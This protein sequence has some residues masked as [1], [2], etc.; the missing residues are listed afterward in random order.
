MNSFR[1]CIALLSVLFLAGAGQA[2]TLKS[3]YGIQIQAGDTLWFADGT[4]AIWTPEGIIGIFTM[5]GETRLANVER[6]EMR[7]DSARVILLDTTVTVNASM[8][9]AVA[10]DL[11]N[12]EDLGKCAAWGESQCVR[13]VSAYADFRAAET[14]NSLWRDEGIRLPTRGAAVATDGGD[15]VRVYDLDN[16]TQVLALE[17]GA[18]NCLQD[19]SPVVTDLDFQDAVLVISGIGGADLTFVDFWLDRAYK[20]DTGG[21]QQYNGALSACNDGSGWR[22]VASG[23]AINDNN[24][25]GISLNRSPFSGQAGTDETGRQRVLWTIAADVKS[26]ANRFNDTG[27]EFIYDSNVSL[28]LTADITAASGMDGFLAVVLGTTDGIY[29][30]RSSLGISADSYIYD[31]V[32]NNT[33]SGSEDL[34]WADPTVLSSVAAIPGISGSGTNSPRIYAAADSGLYILDA[35][36][37]G[38]SD[39]SKQEINN[40]YASPVMPGNVIVAFSPGSTALVGGLSTIFTDGSSP[41]L[42][43]TFTTTDGGP[44]S[45]AYVGNGTRRTTIEDHDSLTFAS[46]ETASISMWVKL[47][48]TADQTF[49]SKGSEYALTISAS[50]FTLRLYDTAGGSNWTQRAI[51]PHPFVTNKWYHVEANIVNDVP[52]IYLDGVSIGSHSTTGTFNTMGDKAT[53]FTFGRQ[54]G[55]M[56]PPVIIRGSTLTGSQRQDAI[57]RGLKFIESPTPDTLRTGGDV[58]D[59]ATDGHY[60]Y[61]VDEATV[62][63]RG[64]EGALVDTFKCAG[65]GTIASIEPYPVGTDSFGFIAGGSGGFRTVV[66]DAK[67]FDLTRQYTSSFR[68]IGAGPIIADT[69]GN[70]HVWKIQDGLDAASSVGI[71]TVR[72][73]YKGTFAENVVISNAGVTLECGGDSTTVVDGTTAGHGISVTGADAAVRDCGAK[74]TKGG[75][76]AF[77][78]WNI[79]GARFTGINLRALGSDDD[80]F[81]LN[82]VHMSLMGIRAHRCDDEG[83]ETGTSFDK[84]QISHLT[85][86]GQVG[87]S[88][89]LVSGADNNTISGKLDGTP[90]DAGSGNQIIFNDT[91]E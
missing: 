82:A 26:S 43:S 31:E 5:D 24:V 90:T 2:E 78:A 20:F 63:V 50:I 9:V 37:L 57:V 58:D 65:C 52:F 1:A 77:D 86:I 17:P 67:V 34:R 60:L 48:S 12:P 25:R 47:S 80:C 61:L 46:G 84:S 29:W 54:V 6:I 83:V 79:T 55:D 68:G 4:A 88:L 81:S 91:A 16:Y 45:H 21:L 13:W 8:S 32:W 41:A 76:T 39:G 3:S 35:K 87:T 59:I 38:N 28:D 66:A 10:W 53:D 33:G 62:E 85:T 22:V 72:A 71:R 74:T 15:T 23:T 75:G 19:A 14:N 11:L 70:G 56:V 89:Q 51:D 30:R 69:A 49:F 36:A 73:P 27:T 44:M 40:R 64:I 42:M 18:N 7:P